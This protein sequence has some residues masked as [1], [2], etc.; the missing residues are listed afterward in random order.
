M[1]LLKFY[2]F[3]LAVV[4]ISTAPVFA[5]PV[6]PDGYIL[7]VVAEYPTADLGFPY[8]L[9]VGPDGVI[10][11]CQWAGSGDKGSI[12]RIDGKGVKTHWVDNVDTPRSIFW[13]GGTAFG[14]NFCVVEAGPRRIIKLDLSGK[15]TPLTSS[16]YQGPSFMDIDRNGSFGGDII[17][18]PRGTDCLQRIKPDGTVSKFSKWPGLTSGGVVEVTISPTKRYNGNIFAVLDDTKNNERDGLYQI[19]GDATSTRF[20]ESLYY[21]YDAKFDI[22]GSM[23][24]NDLFAIALKKDVKGMHLWRVDEDGNAEPL[25]RVGGGVTRQIAFGPDGAMYLARHTPEKTHILRFAKAP[26]LDID[27]TPGNCFNKLDVCDKEGVLSVAVLGTKSFDVSKVDIATV[28]LQG[29]SPIRSNYADVSCPAM[30]DHSCQKPDGMR[31]LTLKFDQKKIVAAIKKL[32]SVR[33]KTEVSL[34][35]TCK[36]MDN[37]SQ[38]KGADVVRLQKPVRFKKVKKTK[39]KNKKVAAAKQLPDKK[40]ENSKL[41]LENSQLRKKKESMLSLNRYYKSIATGIGQNAIRS[42]L[43]NFTLLKRKDTRVALK[44]V[45]RSKLHSGSFHE[46]KFECYVWSNG[47]SDPRKFIATVSE[48][49]GGGAAT[50]VYIKF[51]DFKMEWSMPDW[52]YVRDQFTSMAMTKYVDIEDINFDNPK[53]KWYSKATLSNKK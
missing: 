12:T 36:L 4:F 6:P 2:L 38:L 24:G 40:A 15:I 10:Y 18:A 19:D 42:R 31:D 27:I 20:A 39:K 16:I 14:N 29:V 51:K 33:N 28:K 23:F 32:K 9:T 49:I 13:A 35:L 26:P 48:P 21:V 44:L 52:L 8:E 45:D 5:L 46:V 41:K 3:L 30:E 17:G 22:T 1:S 34:T 50:D 37:E 25:M 11:V 7:E 53:L 47:E 43:G